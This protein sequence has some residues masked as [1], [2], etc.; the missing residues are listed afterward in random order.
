MGV[1]LVD[2]GAEIIQSEQR[3]V[4]FH[5]GSNSITAPFKAINDCY[6]GRDLTSCASGSCYCL[7]N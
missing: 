3:N 7:K 2:L 6:H 5:F 4:V 1:A